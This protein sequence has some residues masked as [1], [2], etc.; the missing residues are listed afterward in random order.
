MKLELEDQPKSCNICEEDNQN[1]KISKFLCEVCFKLTTD[2][3]PNEYFVQSTFIDAFSSCN[4][5]KVSLPFTFSIAF[6]FQMI[7]I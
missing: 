4:R 3:N 5:L 1:L 2:P 6:P 7:L